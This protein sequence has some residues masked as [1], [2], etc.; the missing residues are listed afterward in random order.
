MKI[1][2]DWQGQLVTGADC[3]DFPAAMHSNQ[4]WEIFWKLLVGQF[5]ELS[6]EI[7]DQ[8]VPDSRIKSN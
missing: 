7:E 8:K 6:I 5:T 2:F 3:K 4:E 1:N